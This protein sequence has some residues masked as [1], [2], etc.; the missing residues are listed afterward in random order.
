MFNVGDPEARAFLTNFISDRIAEFGLDWYREDANIAPLEYWRH[1]DAP[2]RQ[3]ITEIRYVEG[4]YALWDE[5]IGRHPHL[6]IDNCASGGR[7]IDLESIGRSTALHRT[8]WARDS[9]H[10]QCHSFG[11][12]QWVPLHLPG[13]GAVLKKGNEYEVRSVMTAGLTTQLWDEAD[14]D[15]GDDARRLLEQYLN[16]RKFYYGDYYPLTPYSQDKGVWLAWQFNLP[17]DREGM[18]QA[19]RRE[20]SVYESARLY[21]HEL[22]PD[23]HYVL[24]DVDAD[25]SCEAS[26]RE[27][28]KILQGDGRWLGFRT[29]RLPR[30]RTPR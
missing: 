6:M 20:E 14:G 11:L 22:V 27:L 25:T 26:G 8:D 13:R 19:F 30:N 21:L 29:Q 5:L 18:V 15:Q 2:D 24:R 16:I 9:I 28:R 17:E 3:G 12:F 10:A 4:I 7:R 1:A 23:A